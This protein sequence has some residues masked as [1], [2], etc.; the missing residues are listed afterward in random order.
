MKNYTLEDLKKEIFK[1]E[2]VKKSYSRE[3]TKIRIAQQ[4]HELREQNHISQKE[5]AKQLH[6]S[7]QAV[8]R[9]EKDNYRPT[10]KTLEKL[11]EIFHKEL[12]IKF[13]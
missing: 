4:I 1:N 13:V 11:A 5:L 6:T 12:Q 2:K 3:L 7:Q 8:S 10:T 9:L